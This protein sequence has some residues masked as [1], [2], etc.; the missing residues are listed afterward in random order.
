[1]DSTRLVRKAIRLEYD[2]R[3]S[4]NSVV[5]VTGSDLSGTDCN[6]CLVQGIIQ[7]F[8]IRLV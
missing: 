6:L 5:Y 8:M 7:G 1:M 3:G 4:M 2:L